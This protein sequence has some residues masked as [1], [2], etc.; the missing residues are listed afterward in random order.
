VASV[1]EQLAGKEPQ[2]QFGRA[3]KTLDVELILA[4]SPQAKGRVER[5]NGVLQDRLVKALRLAGI[6]D[7]ENANRFLAEAFLPA[8]NRRFQRPAASPADVHG[9]VP[10]KLD[11]VLSW[12][13]ERV[14]QRDW[15]VARGGRWHQLDPR[16]EALSLV[17]RKGIVRTLRAGRVQLEY[18][19]TKLRWRAL[20][21]RPVREQPKAAAVKPP[22]VKPPAAHHPWRR[23]DMGVGREYWRAVKL[24]GRA[25]RAAARLAARDSGRPPLRSGLPASRPA[26]R[27]NKGT[28]DKQQRGHSLVS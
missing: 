23:L 11:E 18:R 14:V 6:S 5:M 16:P 10:R 25:M 20:P 13:V 8:F 19:G 28:N 7:P 21:A 2:T 22:A 15:T 12:E 1:A 4:H 9:V 3:M 17:R 24:R 27:G 26:S